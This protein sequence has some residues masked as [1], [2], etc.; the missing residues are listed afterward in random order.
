MHTVQVQVQVQVQ[1]LWQV[2]PSRIN[3]KLVASDVRIFCLFSFAV[4]VL[5]GSF[6]EV[7]RE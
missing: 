5:G 6:F 4:L 7:G 1:V 2:T 3:L